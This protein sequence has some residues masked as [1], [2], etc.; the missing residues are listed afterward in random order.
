M[1][2]HILALFLMAA[3]LVTLHRQSAGLRVERS[4]MAGSALRML[5]RSNTG[6]RLL[7]MELEPSVADTTRIA[8]ITMM[9]MDERQMSGPP[10]PWATGSLS[11]ERIAEVIRAK[12]K[13]AADSDR[14]SG[15]VLVA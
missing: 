3:L 11:D 5:A 2:P 15:V 7:G 6:N 1:R 14:F 9:A 4:M 13:E 12:V 10:K 8:S